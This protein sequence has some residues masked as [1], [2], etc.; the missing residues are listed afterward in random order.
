M[1]FAALALAVAAA[2]VRAPGL[3]RWCYTVDEFYFSQSVGFI[4]DHGVPKFPT[5]G[6]YVRGLLLQYLSAVPALVFGQSEF[7]DRL[8]PLLFGIAGVVAFYALARRYLREPYAFACAA[9][10]ALSSWHI[11]FSRFARFYSAFGFVFVLLLYALY[12]GYWRHDRRF[13]AAAWVIAFAAPLIYEAAVF[14]P[15][16]MAL[17]ILRSESLASGRNL[18][19]AAGAGVLLAWN[20]LV[21]GVNY[22]NW[23]VLDSRPPDLAVPEAGRGDLKGPILDLASVATSSPGLSVALAVLALF[24]LWVAV[25]NRRRWT[26]PFGAALGLCF[27]GLPLIHQY[28]TL[29]LVSV[30]YALAKPKR[31]DTLVSALR[32]W[33]PYL[34][35]SVAFWLAVGLLSSAWH[36]GAGV[37]GRTLKL[38]VAL[39]SHFGIHASLV[40]PFASSAPILGAILVLAL[41]ASLIRNL[42]ATRADLSRFPLTVVV[43][44][45]F[46][47]PLFDTTYRTTR[48]SFFYYP[49]A[50][51]LLFTETWA[52]A[53]RLSSGAPARARLVRRVAVV[54]ALVA[55]A[56]SEDFFAR[57]LGDV[58]APDVNFRT[59]RYE[60]LQN[61]WYARF[62]YE[63]PARFV[64]E[65]YRPGDV[66]VLDAV[67]SSRYLEHPFVNYVSRDLGRFRGVSR[68]RGTRELWTG[69][70]LRYD[71]EGLAGLV[72]AKSTGCLWL[73]AAATRHSAG[74][75]ATRADVEAFAAQHGLHA[76][77]EMAGVDGRLGVWRI[78]RNGT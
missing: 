11:E 50:L 69:S 65:R 18:R 68:E 45:V 26:D 39:F 62:D 67:V 27:L 5:G 61:H 75:F 48:Y 53:R 47:L 70:P 31:R 41:A 59:G 6:Y 33:T 4:L 55:L 37:P 24:G 9:A 30:L 29:A 17:P 71:P 56:G 21:T 2:A 10:L 60:P 15:F 77:L 74:S 52:V 3:G 49:I 8:V 32:A 35:A 16:F 54:L 76:S 63:S 40:R 57:R 1:G 28:G 7:T 73:I 58:S 23:G 14:L 44:C 66:I 22:R 19:L 46:L 34:V 43:L 51:S 64:N 38:G 36:P 72:P 20:Y 12:R 78:L 25:R 13:A 42:R